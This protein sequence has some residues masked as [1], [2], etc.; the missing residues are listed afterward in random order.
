MSAADPTHWWLAFPAARPPPGNPIIPPVLTTPAVLCP[1][2]GRTCSFGP[3]D[4]KEVSVMCV[5]PPPLPMR[6]G[7]RTAQGHSLARGR[8][9]QRGWEWEGQQPSA[10]SYQANL[11]LKRAVYMSR[12]WR[13]PFL[14]GSGDP[15]TWRCFCGVGGL[16]AG[17][18]GGTQN[19]LSSP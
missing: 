3:T 4:T 5:P 16:C 12:G 6:L 2:L 1:P 17:Q 14:K 8:Q 10:R 11:P 19:M 9:K 7:L 13:L 15:S 18:P